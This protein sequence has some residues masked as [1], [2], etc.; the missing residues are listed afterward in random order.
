[1]TAPFLDLVRHALTAADRDAFYRR[2]DDGSMTRVIRGVAVPTATWHEADGAERHRILVHAAL[3]TTTQRV[4]VAGVSAA[5]LHELP[6]VGHL[7]PF[8]EVAHLSNGGRASRTLRITGLRPAS[9]VDID[10]LDVVELARA[11]ADVARS[12]DFAQAVVVADA[13]AA[14]SP[15]VI[16]EALAEIDRLPGFRGGVRAMDALAFADAASE[17]PGESLSR[18]SMH[19]MRLPAPVLQA[20][21]PRSAGRPW[22][23]DF[24]WPDHG[25][26]GEFDGESKYADNAPGTLLAEKVREDDLRARPQVRAFVRWDWD[27]ASSPVALAEKLARAGVYPMRVRR[28]TAAI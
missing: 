8:A 6:W 22:R 10:G 26:I 2:I 5:V 23:V 7:P 14:R 1:M 28:P 18:A 19:R 12:C 27:T 4:A 20:E 17:S 21:F 13:A 11:V 9:T 15:T 3:A 16:A 24:W 25:V